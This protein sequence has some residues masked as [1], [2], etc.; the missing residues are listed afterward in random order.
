MLYEAY[1]LALVAVVISVVSFFSAILA[2][3]FSRK[4]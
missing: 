1:N 2:L 3:Y 4:K